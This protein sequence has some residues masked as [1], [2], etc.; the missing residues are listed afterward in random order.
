[1][2]KGH[3]GNSAVGPS[4]LLKGWELWE[5][6][7]VQA[8]LKGQEGPTGFKAK[9]AVPVFLQIP[10][11]MGNV[12]LKASVI[13]RRETFPELREDGMS[14]AEAGSRAVMAP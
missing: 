6:G 13:Q 5:L 1:M 11:M 12:S 4:P 9:E 7:W 3:G 2:R 14:E 8:Q 10:L